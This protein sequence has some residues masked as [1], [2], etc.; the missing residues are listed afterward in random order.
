DSAPQAEPQYRYHVTN[1]VQ[2][3][4]RDID[5]VGDI[6]DAAIEAGAN[7]TYGVEFRVDDQ[8]AARSEARAAA[9]DNANAKAAELAGLTNVTVGQVLSVS[10]IIGNSGFYGAANTSAAFGLGGGGTPI[11]AGE[12]QLS[13]QVQVTYAIE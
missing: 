4:I 1:Q 13:V 12:L 6:I 5:Q 7:S 3:T 8:D 9:I 10:E 11:A 2:V